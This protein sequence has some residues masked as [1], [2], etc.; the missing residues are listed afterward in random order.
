L[1]PR[2]LAVVAAVALVALFAAVDA[3]R[4]SPP[5]GAPPAARAPAPALPGPTSRHVQ[6]LMKSEVDLHSVRANR[7]YCRRDLAV[8]CFER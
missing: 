2:N 5:A 1:K 6:E 4:T 3:F 8:L 7:G